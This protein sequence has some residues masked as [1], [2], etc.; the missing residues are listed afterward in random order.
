MSIG[1]QTLSFS[2]LFRN[3]NF[4][5]LDCNFL[6]RFLKGFE[7]WLILLLDSSSVKSECGEERREDTCAGFLVWKTEGKTPVGRQ[8]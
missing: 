3:M 4:N 7:I 5:D 2:W 1:E 6:L 8:S